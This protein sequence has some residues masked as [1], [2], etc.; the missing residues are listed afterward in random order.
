[1]SELR[2]HTESY[3]ELL[4]LPHVPCLL[5]R[6]HG[7][8]NSHNLRFLLDKGLELYQAHAPRYPRLG[9]VADTRRFGAMPPADQQWALHSWNPRAY[10]AGIRHLIF[11][12]PDTIFGQIALQQYAHNLEA[13]A[14]GLRATYVSSL[15]AAWQQVLATR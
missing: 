5:I 12:S 15:D 2:L 7:F 11:V 3:G 9:W 6:W 14:L 10:A 8:A 4:L 1:M 13:A